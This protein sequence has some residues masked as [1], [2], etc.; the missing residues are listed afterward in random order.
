MKFT[1]II[2]NLCIM[3]F[4]LG[5]CGAQDVD[6][7]PHDRPIWCTSQMEIPLIVTAHV[8]GIGNRVGNENQWV[9]DGNYHAIEEFKIEFDSNRMHRMFRT[10]PDFKIQYMCH[11]SG[12]GDTYWLE[13]GTLCGKAERVEEFAV[14]LEGS[15][16]RHFIVNY[17]C[18]VANHGNRPQNANGRCG[19]RGN[20]VEKMKISVKSLGRNCQ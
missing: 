3:A 20:A 9:G 19:V 18:H 12:S 17:E 8:A 11:L 10:L 5:A 2:K 7:R 4:I 14:K 6:V 1:D 13:A 16:A 15:D